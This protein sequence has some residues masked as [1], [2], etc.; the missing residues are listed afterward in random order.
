MP[1]ASRPRARRTP[2]GAG[3]DPPQ[4]GR[5][6]QPDGQG[7]QHRGEQG[8]RALDVAGDD[9]GQGEHGDHDDHDVEH[10]EAPP[11]GRWDAA[12]QGRHRL[13]Q[14]GPGRQ[15]DGHEA[16]DDG[17]AHGRQAAASAAR[18]ARPRA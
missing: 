5:P 12:K 13:A 1:L 14:H 17:D 11:G 10:P 8:R 16:A 9:P 3:R 4:Q 2:A 6:E 15:V 18:A 7:E